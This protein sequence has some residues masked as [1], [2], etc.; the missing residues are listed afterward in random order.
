V[1]RRWPHSRRREHVSFAHHAELTAHPPATQDEWLDRIEKERLS[2]AV[3][4]TLLR[5]HLSR[6]PPLP[7][8]PKPAL[9]MPVL[10]A[11]PS[12]R[13]PSPPP[14]SPPSPPLT[15]EPVQPVAPDAAAALEAALQTASL[16][17]GRPAVI[18]L[19]QQW[20]AREP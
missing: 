5:P 15:P 20:I 6:P 12:L 1:A 18:A 7:R 13:P 19:L 3:F 2:V 10:P 9:P 4:R 14:P 16:A 17:L 11:P 8:L